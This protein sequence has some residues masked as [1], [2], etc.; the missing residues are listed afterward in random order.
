LSKPQTAKPQ[1]LNAITGRPYT[2]SER[3]FDCQQRPKEQVC[4]QLPTSTDHVA[5]PAF[6][7]ARRVAARQLLIAGG[8]AIDRYILA[9]GPTAANPPHVASGR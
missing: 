6:A 9:A 3:R 5:L 7:A 4:V 1:R 8:A 2:S